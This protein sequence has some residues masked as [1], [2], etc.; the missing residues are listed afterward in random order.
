MG[1]GKWEVGAEL[2]SAEGSQCAAGNFSSRCRP[3]SR[4]TAKLCPRDPGQRVQA[5]R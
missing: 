5:G 4:F 3:R 2:Q 1:G